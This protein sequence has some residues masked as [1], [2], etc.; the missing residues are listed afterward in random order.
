MRIAS[1]ATLLL[2][3]V[4]L[5]ACATAW[6]PPE[7][8]YDDTP[9]PAV[10]QPDPPKPVQIVE[11]PKPLPLPGQLKPLP[12]G[13]R[14]AAG[15]QPIRTRASTSANGAARVQPTRAGYLNAI[16]VYP[17]SDG[18]LYQVYAAPGEDHGHRARAGRAAR[19]LRPGRGRRH[20]ALD[21]RRHRERR[22]ARRS[23]STFW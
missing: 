3:S 6:K 23:A 11:L 18:A 9:K 22:R 7:I 4:S 15:S 13:D 19:R 14:S 17:F 10:L 1:L 16:Q 2:A 8:S 12:R 20:R 5:G 21:H